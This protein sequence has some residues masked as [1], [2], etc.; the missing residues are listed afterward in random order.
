MGRQGGGDREGGGRQGEEAGRGG[1]ERQAGRGRERGR[2]GGRRER[3]GGSEGEQTWIRREVVVL[4][5]SVE[6]VPSPRVLLPS[7]SN[8]NICS[9]HSFQIFT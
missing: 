5:P 1:R 7:N 8:G 6:R 2:E 4:S 3:P 9:S